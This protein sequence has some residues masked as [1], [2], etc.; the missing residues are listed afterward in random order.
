MS[1]ELNDSTSGL[2][3]IIPTLKQGFYYENVLKDISALSKEIEESFGNWEIITVENMLVNPAWN[4][5]VEEAKYDKIMIINDDI[6][7]YPK[8]FE[9]FAKTAEKMWVWCP[10][11]S[12]KID[13]NTVYDNN[14]NNIV[15]FCFGMMKSDWKPIPD[16]LNLWWGDNYIYEYMKHRIRV[17][18][19][20]HHFESKTL[21]SPE[22]KVICERIIDQ[23][24]KVWQAIKPFL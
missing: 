11:F 23:D 19:R 15:G 24:R 12:R 9:W 8:T 2:S 6:V 22:K 1:H 18:G 20:I 5:G 3:I 4:R 17:A 10:K 14:A 21:T 16:G 7:F 13:L